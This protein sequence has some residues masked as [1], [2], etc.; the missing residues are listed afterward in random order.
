M[1]NMAN[2]RQKVTIDPFHAPTHN[3]KIVDGKLV[4][5]KQGNY[6]WWY[7][8]IGIFSPLPF[9]EFMETDRWVVVCDWYHVQP[10]LFHLTQKLGTP[11]YNGGPL[12]EIPKSCEEID[13]VVQ[14]I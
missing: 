11:T 13:L 7:G 6:Q 4:Y 1:I 5:E 2:D 12:L 10:Q 14:Y 8:W 3:A 9:P